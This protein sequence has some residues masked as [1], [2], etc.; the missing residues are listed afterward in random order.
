MALFTVNLTFSRWFD[1]SPRVPHRS[2][3]FIFSGVDVWLVQ[4]YCS[5][6][7]PLT[8]STL[9]FMLVID[10]LE[11]N[12]RAQ[13]KHFLSVGGCCLFAFRPSIL[14]IQPRSHRYVYMCFICALTCQSN[15]WNCLLYEPNQTGGL[16]MSCWKWEGLFSI[17][18]KECNF[19]INVHIYVL[20]QVLGRLKNTLMSNFN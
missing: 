18:V 1:P 16:K 2:T 10:V 8:S 19:V 14:E 5:C 7:L 13:F 12:T 11:N 17:P 4:T 15:D 20:V 6:T 9:R 3:R